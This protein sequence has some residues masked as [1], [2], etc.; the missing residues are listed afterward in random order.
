[1]TSIADTP[2]Q[3]RAR[4]GMSL[5]E[6]EIRLKE[7]EFEHRR[8]LDRR[9]SR[10][11][12][13]PYA[14][15]LIAI[16]T[17]ALTASVSGL[18]SRTIERD[19]A[20]REDQLKSREQQF[21]IV[22]KATENRT[23]EEAAK[24]LLFFVDIGYLPDSAGRIREKAK[25]GNVP[26]IT[27]PGAG[28]ANPLRARLDS[29]A[30]MST[31]VG[32]PPPGLRHTVRGHILFDG[33]GK[34]VRTVPTPSTSRLAEAR[35]VVVH[36]TSTGDLETTTSALS[37]SALKGSAHIVV[38]RDGTIVQMAPFDFA[39]LHAGASVWRGV[40][41]LNRSSIGIELVNWGRL[42][43]R[44]SRWVTWSNAAVPAAEVVEVRDP[45]TGT[46]TGW[47]RF[48]EAQLQAV[49]QLIPVLRWYY[50]SL[51]ELVSHQQIAPQRKVDPGPA[52]P[53]EQMQRVLAAAKPGA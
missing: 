30:A 44:G 32:P 37:D 19:K 22:L 52:F 39:T 10:L 5:E 29:L 8:M 41:N 4:A 18:W 34:P 13:P 45:A 24:N 51:E 3:P 42:T 50:P 36:S 11:S 14:T 40:R 31:P 28:T 43:R 17:T 23:P 6:R 7:L 21:Q 9:S 33:A 47:H 35:F 46:V 53:L 38:G 25:A 12:I 1:M 20:V 15:A 16:V 48:T 2:E 27:T 49:A 26:V